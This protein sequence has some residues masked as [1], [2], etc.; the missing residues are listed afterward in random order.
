[1]AKATVRG[2]R[3][4]DFAVA[5]LEET[6]RF[7]GGIWGLRPVAQTLETRYFRGASRYHHILALRRAEK[8]AIVRVVFEVADRR[9]LAEL[10]RAV[11]AVG[12]EVSASRDVRWPGGGHGFGC[13]DPEGRNLVFVCDVADHA[14]EEPER[15]RPRKISHVNLNTGSVDATVKFFIDALGFRFADDS[16][17]LVFL[18]CDNS[19]HHSVVIARDEAATLN[20]VAFEMADLDAVMRG[21]GRLKDAGYPI[22]W[23][24]GRHGAGDNVFCYFAGPEEC[25]IEYTAEVQQVDEKYVARGPEHWKFQPG[26]SDQWGITAPRS[27]RLLRVQQLFRFT[28]DGHRLDD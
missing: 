1:M 9:T 2:V 12:V 25:P 13:K 26:R 5:D 11:T 21:G 14:M 23:G 7:Y 27:A 4:V 8:P 20:H 6:A 28:E 19:D 16:G 22:E 18:R 3:C 10:H 24:P 17:H 15:D